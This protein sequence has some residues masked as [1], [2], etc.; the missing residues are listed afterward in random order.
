MSLQQPTA[1]VAGVERSDTQDAIRRVSLR[2]TR[3]T[4]TPL[5]TIQN[6]GARA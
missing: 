4:A 5:S 6:K 3:A 2:S 1:P